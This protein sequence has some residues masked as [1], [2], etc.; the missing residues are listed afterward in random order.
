VPTNPSSS[1]FEKDFSKWLDEIPKIVF[2]S[3]LEKIEWMNARLVKGDAAKEITMLKR[4]SGKNFVMWGGS[5]FPQALM[6]LELIDEYWINVH[7]TIIGNGKP[8][9][10]DIKNRIDLKLL[11]SKTFES[12]TV[13]LRYQPV[14]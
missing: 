9:F 12:G 1:R 2:S 5:K 3:T 14:K 13:A 11:D 10:S 7:R 6:N 8:L 4:Q